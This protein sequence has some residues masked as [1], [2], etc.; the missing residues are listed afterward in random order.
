M[1]NYTYPELKQ[2]HITDYQNIFNRAKFALKGA[3][4]DNKRT[5]DQQLF[6][7]TEKEEQ[8]PYLEILYFQYGRYLLISCSRTPGI[9]ANLQGLWAPARKSPWRGNYTININLEENYWPAEVTNMS[10]LVMPVDG[11]VKAMS[12][13][14]NIQQ[15]TIMELKW[16]VRWTQHRRMGNDQSCWNQE[17]ES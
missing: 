9:P 6:D 8:N 1:V 17:R 4:F 13:T 2:R 11:L 16:L 12:V 15:S 5:T 14:G 3:K 7:Y 10:E